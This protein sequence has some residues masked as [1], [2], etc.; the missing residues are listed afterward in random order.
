MRIG[1]APAL[2]VAPPRDKRDETFRPLRHGP[3]K[4][5]QIAPYS[6]DSLRYGRGVDADL[7]PGETWVSSSG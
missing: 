5:D 4:P 2:Y 1:F 6:A 7:D 3:Q